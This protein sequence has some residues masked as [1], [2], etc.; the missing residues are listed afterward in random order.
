MKTPTEYMTEIDAIRTH[1]LHVAF[2]RFPLAERMSDPSEIEDC[3]PSFQWG[4]AKASY[5]QKVVV[6]REAKSVRYGL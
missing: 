2:K 4:V 3:M 5:A 6:L 1:L